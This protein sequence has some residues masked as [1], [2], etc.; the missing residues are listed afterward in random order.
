MYR[1]CAVYS[2]RIGQ[3]DSLV[4]LNSYAPSN[5][6]AVTVG[7]TARKFSWQDNSNF[8]LGF[9]ID[10]KLETDVTFK[11]IGRVPANT[12]TFID[13][14]VILTDTNYDYRICADY[15]NGNS[16]NTVH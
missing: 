7:E 5:F 15:A 8:E 3:Y 13:T 6:I 14:A 10:R 9:H 2:N 4:I 11:T 12:T 16:T 1:V